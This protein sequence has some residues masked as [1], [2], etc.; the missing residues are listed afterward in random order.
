MIALDRYERLKMAAVLFHVALALVS[1]RWK[2]T[3]LGALRVLTSLTEEG[4]E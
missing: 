2:P 3:R 4:A 1:G